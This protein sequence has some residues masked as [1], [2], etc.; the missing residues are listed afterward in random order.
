MSKKIVNLISTVTGRL[1][2]S[3]IVCFSALISFVRA[4]EHASASAPKSAESE[5][6]KSKFVYPKDVMREPFESLV[7]ASGTLNVKM[8]RQEGDLKLTGIVYGG[9]TPDV[10]VIN[11]EVFYEGDIIGVYQVK[12]ISPDRVRL[13]S[14]E[15]EIELVLPE[16]MVYAQPN[17][18]ANGGTNGK[19]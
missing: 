3:L 12:K 15:K 10:V 7:D 4:D 6:K 1:W 13:M 11:N 8:V 17:T 19:K 9:N 5:A 14:A 16:E 18:N 2:L